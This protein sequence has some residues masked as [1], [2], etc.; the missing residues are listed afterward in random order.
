LT[1]V[2]AA[3]AKYSGGSG[4]TD[5]P[6]QIA[7]A[8]DLIALGETPGDYDKHFILTADIDLDPSLP[9]RKV[10][11][12]AVIAPDTD[13][14]KVGFQ[15]IPFTGVFD[16]NGKTITGLTCN[17]SDMT[18]LGL[19]ACVQGADALITK[20]HLRGASIKA[21]TGGLVGALVGHLQSGRIS[22][23][24]V[25]GG[26][27]R[28]DYIAG[29]L[30]GQCDG[31]IVSSC[32]SASVSVVGKYAGGL[33]GANY[34]RIARCYTTGQIAADYGAGLAGGNY[35]TIEDCFSTA[36]VAAKTR[37]AG[38]L[39]AM[40]GGTIRDSYAAGKVA[41]P[42]FVGGL[43]GQGTGPVTNSFWDV[44][45]SGQ[46]TSVGGVGKSTVQMKQ[47][48]TFAGWD[49]VS[50]WMIQEGI[51]Y[52]KLQWQSDPFAA[53]VPTSIEKASGDNEAGWAGSRAAAPLAVRVRDQY[54]QGIGGVLVEFT[55]IAGG[56]TVEPVSAVTNANGLASTG[57]TL[58]PT[59]GLNQVKASVSNIS[60]DFNIPGKALPVATV[61]EKASGD[62]RYAWAGAKASAALTV[63]VRDQYGQGIGGVLVEF[64]VIAGG[65][66]VEPVSAVTNANGLA[67]TGLTLGPTPGTN[68][69]KAVAGGLSTSFEAYG[70]A[71][72]YTGGSGTAQDPYQIATAVDLILLGDTPADYDK[73]FILTADADLDPKLPGR[74]VFDGAV[75]APDTNPGNDT[76]RFDGTAFNGVFD[77]NG[78]AISHLTIKG[79]GFLGL[80]GQLRTGAKIEDLG[81]VD[82]NITG[83]GDYVGALVGSSNGVLIRCWSVGAVSGKGSV[84]GLVGHSGRGTVSQCYNTGAVRGTGWSVGG[85]VGQNYEG[86][87]ILCYST[88]TVGGASGVGGL[89][90]Y[91]GSNLPHFERGTVIQCYSAGA[92]SGVGPSVGGLVGTGL[93]GDITAC[94]WDTQTSG[95]TKSAGGTGKTTAQMRDL[96]TY[97]G[98]GWDFVGETANG[99]SEIWQMPKE[100]GYPILGVFHGYTPP[101]LQGAGTPGDPFLIHDALQLGA[102]VHYR[103]DAHYR[104]AASVDL[105]GIRWG[106]PVIPT[107]AGTFDGDGHT[108]SACLADWSQGPRSRKWG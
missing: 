11:D 89:V 10:F 66:T 2:S 27:I 95:Q 16:G 41:G 82:V 7:T 93:A 1:I 100:G 34:G 94:F 104:L 56:G 102:M 80:F 61:I 15:G 63:C 25:D 44:G 53:S 72:G 90:G 50:T 19:F 54:G 96:R 86:I 49:F 39:V 38:G 108:I 64:T 55:V 21:G 37:G 3:T 77:G 40:N 59:P 75:I 91:N 30:V 45:T 32:S 74:K 103:A 52:P 84:G 88:G 92:V 6:Y 20:V 35:G 23:C 31:E 69:V 29:G 33:A 47:A 76:W 71:R 87:V 14:Q 81:V 46:G 22:R 67:S 24:R 8:A 65:G 62:G 101:Q 17:K 105:S 60:V 85:L 107:F 83:S 4:T 78:H 58:G 51:D 79:A 57:L 48:A 73:H 42:S 36:Q 106:I 12:R 99:T 18:G 28:G 68:V 9:G 98:A 26:S 43:V 97:L 13:P 70:V 5:D